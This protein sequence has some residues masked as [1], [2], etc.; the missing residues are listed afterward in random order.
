MSEMQCLLSETQLLCHSHNRRSPM[1][2][3]GSP[4]SILFQTHTLQ[5]H[6]LERN[7]KYVKMSCLTP[8]LLEFLPA[9]S[10]MGASHSTL[11]L[12]L[13]SLFALC[14][15]FS[16]HA[17]YCPHSRSWTT[18]VART[19]TLKEKKSIQFE[20]LFPSPVFGKLLWRAI[21]LLLRCD[22]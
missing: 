22:F 8:V 5:H 4:L 21:D 20:F 1:A 16:A 13:L 17:P 9:P 2:G 6:D 19:H 18:I 15:R 3:Y 12:F 7:G 14:F 10:I 11:V